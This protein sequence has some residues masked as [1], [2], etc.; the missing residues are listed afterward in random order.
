MPVSPPT[1]RAIAGVRRRGKKNFQG[2]LARYG[3]ELCLRTTLNFIAA[4]S[5]FES[6]DLRYGLIRRLLLLEFG[7][8]IERTRDMLQ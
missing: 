5:R 3:F 2:I 7:R 8:C 4:Y 1:E 6:L